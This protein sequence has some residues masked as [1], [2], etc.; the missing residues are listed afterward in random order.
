MTKELRFAS[1]QRK[2]I[3]PIDSTSQ[4]DIGSYT[5]YLSMST[6]AL[7]HGIE[8]PGRECNSYY[9]LP[10]LRIGGAILP[11]P[12]RLRGVHR[13]NFI[14]TVRGKYILFAVVGRAV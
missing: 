8:R 12:I 1:R 3:F 14:V 11:V 9:L 10:A 6:G 4:T 2:G 7:V 13:D 5:A